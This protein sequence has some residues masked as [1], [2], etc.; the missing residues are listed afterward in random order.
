MKLSSAWPLVRERE[1]CRVW[2]QFQGLA[3]LKLVFSPS[4]N[5]QTLLVSQYT[6]PPAWVLT[7]FTNSGILN[8]ETVCYCTFNSRFSI[9]IGN[10]FLSVWSEISIRKSNSTDIQVQMFQTGPS[11]FKLIA[12]TVNDQ[13]QGSRSRIGILLYFQGLDF[14]LK[15]FAY[16]YNVAADNFPDFLCWN[17][18]CNFF[19]TRH[20]DRFL[21]HLKSK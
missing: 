2:F 19:I 13:D 18:S 20:C 5:E 12:K 14:K 7:D 16:I 9:S 11:P 8:R 21:K 4:L 10:I 1:S 17:K 6:S 15:I 3:S